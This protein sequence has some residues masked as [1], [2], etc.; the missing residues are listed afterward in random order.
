MVRVVI[1]GLFVAASGVGCAAIL[2]GSG[3]TVMFSS[4]PPGAKVVAGEVEGLTP[5]TVNVRKSVGVVRFLPPDP[6]GREVF[7]KLDHTYMWGYLALDILLTPGY[8]AVGCL[9]DAATQ[10]WWNPPDQVH[11]DFATGTVEK[12]GRKLSDEEVEKYKEEE[13]RRKEQKADAASPR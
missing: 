5:F 8:G 13:A 10:A 4:H 9:V 6:A 11:Y 7:I 2:D 3:D 1:L 12:G